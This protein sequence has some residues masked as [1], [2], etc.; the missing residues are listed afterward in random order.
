ML[1][2][3]I[4]WQMIGFIRSLLYIDYIEKESNYNFFFPSRSISFKLC[5][6]KLYDL[7][8]T[9]LIHF[10][11]TFLQLF[12]IRKGCEEFDSFSLVPQQPSLKHWK[13]TH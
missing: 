2:Y 11:C 3:F 4:K 13:N 1:L 12:E 9:V 7:K 5:V 6:S 10:F 8:T